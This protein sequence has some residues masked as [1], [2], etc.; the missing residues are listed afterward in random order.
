MTLINKEYKTKNY[1]LTISYPKA[2]L[3]NSNVIMCSHHYVNKV[4]KFIDK[5]NI[6][7]LDKDP[8]NKHQRR[9]KKSNRVLALT[10][11]TRRLPT[12]MSPVK[13]GFLVVETSSVLSN[14][15]GLPLFV[16]PAHTEETNS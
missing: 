12:V 11:E 6:L 14:T 2:D 5:N 15:R 10:K 9:T 1:N 3:G 4:D 16:S 13:A 7:R 8:T